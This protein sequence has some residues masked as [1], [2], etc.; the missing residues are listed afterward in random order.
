ML[1]SQ[2]SLQSFY[3]ERFSFKILT[4]THENYS[5]LR[6]FLIQF[7]MRTKG[8]LNHANLVQFLQTARDIV[9]RKAY[10]EFRNYCIVLQHRNNDAPISLFDKSCQEN[11]LGV[12]IFQHIPRPSGK[13]NT[14]WVN[15]SWIID[16]KEFPEIL[17]FTQGSSFSALLDRIKDQFQGDIAYFFSKFPENKETKAI[18]KSFK[19]KNPD[20]KSY[21]YPYDEKRTKSKAYPCQYRGNFGLFWLNESFDPLQTPTDLDK[22][23]KS[24]NNLYALFQKGECNVIGKV[25]PYW[26]S[27]L[28]RKQF[29]LAQYPEIV[30]KLSILK[31]FLRSNLDNSTFFKDL[32]AKMRSVG[33]RLY[34]EEIPSSAASNLVN[35]FKLDLII[36]F[37]ESIPSQGSLYNKILDDSDSGSGRLSLKLFDTEH[38]ITFFGKFLGFLTLQLDSGEVICLGY[39]RGDYKQKTDRYSRQLMNGI[40]IPE[41]FRG[42]S[43]GKILTLSGMNQV[44]KKCDVFYEDATIFNE[45]TKRMISTLGFRD[46]GT[47]KNIM[48]GYNPHLKKITALNMRRKYWLNPDFVKEQRQLVR[49]MRKSIN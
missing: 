32:D 25:A 18:L 41:I 8:F 29:L 22:L 45:G 26:K 12:L 42:F 24:A 1:K 30:E 44:L 19:R 4:V 16:E 20:F 33:V 11:T 35:Q 15:I 38:L 36:N 34:I 31:D 39:A 43:L 6:D 9:E 3:D 23:W 46:F 7:K 37:I 10:D 27:L 48:Y 28:A 5:D 13:L 17:T 49:N 40:V 2:L 14:E 47:M 21:Y